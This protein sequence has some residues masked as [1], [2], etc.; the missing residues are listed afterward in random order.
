M[1]VVV[2][3]GASSGIGEEL[4]RQ[5]VAQGYGVALFARRLDKLKALEFE[6][7]QIVPKSARAF[8]CDVSNSESVRAAS[9]SVVE[10]CT[11]SNAKVHGV[12]A[13]AG[14][15][16]AGKVE[17]LAVEDFR[18]QFETNVFGVLE[19]FYAFKDALVQSK[20]FFAI[21]GSVNSFL[22]LPTAAAYCMSKFS[23]RAFAEALK[24]E[25][26]P[27][28]VSVTLI[29]PGFV[30]TEIR[31]VNNQGQFR[32]EAKDP[33]PEWL[34]MS[35]SLAAR[36]VISAVH[37]KKS[38]EIITFHGKVM[39]WLERHFPYALTPFKRSLSRSSQAGSGKW[40]E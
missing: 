37:R 9:A 5:W 11:E 19:T 21:V 17:E 29:C 18:R 35:A 16:V 7:N 22:S 36:K 4:A 8:V 15:G 25:M 27:R 1:K 12:V 33:V 26:E 6:L 30:K 14:F 13:N 38:L 2:I 23:V 10:W 20:G 40:N 32:I 28:G 34:M 3:T 39:V 31:K 24:Y